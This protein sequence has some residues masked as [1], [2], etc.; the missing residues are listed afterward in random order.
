MIKKHYTNHKET[1][2]NF[3]WRSL[4][5][6]GKQG[7]IFLIF[8]L[9]A[10]LLTPYDFGI[11]NYVLAIVF[12]LIIFG[13]F[14]ISTATSK[15][16]AE[17]NATDKEK[18]KYVLFN[19]G[20]IILGLT[21]VI[22]LLTL[23]IGPFYLK[24]KYIYVLYLLP[25]IF[26]APMTSLYDGIYRGLKKFKQLAIISTIIGL[27][28]IPM[29]YFFVKNYGLIG[30][31]ISQNI[32]YFILLLGLGVGFREFKI[33]W[34]K[35]IINQIGSYSLWI[36]LG[37]IGYIFYARID[38]IFLGYYGFIEEIGYYEIINKI[39]MLVIMPFIIIGQVIAPD[40][41]SLYQKRNI[42]RIKNKFIK[43]LFISALS[44][45]LIVFLL[46]C[47]YSMIFGN[48][49]NEYNTE[50]MQK[51]FYL[52]LIVFFTQILNGVIPIGFVNATGHAKLGFYFLGIFGLLHL[53][54]N[55]IFINAFGFIGIV[56]SI[57]ITKSLAD[58]TFILAYY[59]ILRS[60][61]EKV[62]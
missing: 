56:Y 35:S 51:I 46:A 7:I 25:L 13:D 24:E 20:I 39:L 29:V 28:S 54:L 41:T 48:F 45:I 57:I 42:N 49:L 50:A 19:S 12:F 31:L 15:Y 61:N 43:Y 47:S 23:L 26:L 34:N 11:Y 62:N 33:K 40:I 44:S 2:D 59:L 53:T 38:T 1:I 6:F 58:V 4:Q 16:V 36:G 55:Y 52:M 17:Y 27:I 14:G 8:I 21:I 37:G 10:K 60:K 22:T 5:I 18:I 32:F 30:A 9:C 3:L